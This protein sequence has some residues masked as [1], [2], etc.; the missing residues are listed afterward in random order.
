VAICVEFTVAVY[1]DTMRPCVL[2]AQ[3]RFEMHDKTRRAVMPSP[4]LYALCGRPFSGKT[5]LA[6]RLRAGFG[7]PIVSVDEI[8]FAHGF[9]WIEDSPITEAE[10]ARIFGESYDRTRALLRTGTSVI[11]DCA[12]LSRASRDALRELAA[13]E[14]CSYRL[15]FVDISVDEARVRWRRNRD[16]RERFDLPESLFEWALAAFER[17]LTDEHPVVYDPSADVAQVVEP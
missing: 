10:W 8:K 17:P 5:V 1:S 9:P 13:E 12:N 14:G 16:T 3:G 6:E 4:T 15:V 7:Y 11:Y 2:P